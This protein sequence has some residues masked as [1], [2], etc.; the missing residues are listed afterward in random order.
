MERRLAKP[1]AVMYGSLAIAFLIAIPWI[2]WWTLIPLLASGLTYS[3]LSWRIETSARPEY[4]VAA[5]VVNA[6]ILIG[7]GTA[8]SG[9]PHSPTI[10]MLLLPIITLPA[11]FTTRGVYAGVGLSV[12]SCC[13]SPRSPST[14]P[15]SLRIRPSRSS[16]ASCAGLAAFAEALMR[17]EL[18]Q[19]SDAVLDPLTGLLNR[20]TLEQRFEEL[21]QQA[22][23]IGSPVSLIVCDLDHFKKVNDEHGH[24]FGDTVLKTSAN[25]LR[26][27]VG[28]IDHLARRRRGVPGRAAGLRAGRG[29]QR[30]PS[31][32]ASASR[33][34]APAGSQSPRRSGSPPQQAP[35]PPSS[36]SSGRPTKRSTRRSA[37][38]AT[39]WSKPAS[40]SSSPPERYCQESTKVMLTYVRT[41]DS[42][43][44]WRQRREA[45]VHGPARRAPRRGGERMRGL[46][47]RAIGCAAAA[48]TGAVLLAVGTAAQAD[49][50]PNQATFRDRVGDGIKTGQ[51]GV[52]LFNYGTL[53]QQRRQSDQQ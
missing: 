14:P 21:A 5:T 46:R 47:R 32:C 24:A 22:T 50:G 4:V 20:N 40:R 23:L 41:R 26:E 39:V 45:Q 7:I 48:A 29:P 3:L 6:Q 51:M 9:G 38:A 42:V 43:R 49:V 52:Q 8:L 35:A 16:A 44:A 12:V 2:G 27:A 1:R 31:A 11:R 15:A 34:P 18:Q 17:V 25:L 36:R 30:S 10:T 53:H 37:P 28:T 33:T 19:R 13:C